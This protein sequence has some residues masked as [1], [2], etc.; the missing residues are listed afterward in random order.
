MHLRGTTLVA[1][2]RATLRIGPIYT[3]W[4]GRM[5]SPVTVGVR[6]NLLQNTLARLLST[7]SSGGDIR[8]TRSAASHQPAAL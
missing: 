6:S 5:L 3:V 2:N 7:E 4:C 8:D 1:R